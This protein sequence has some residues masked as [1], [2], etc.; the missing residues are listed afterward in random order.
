[1]PVAW[2]YILDTENKQFKLPRTKHAFT[3]LRDSVGGY[4]KAGLPN[5]TGTIGEGLRAYNTT[6][7][8]YEV[9][10][11]AKA[12]TDGNYTSTNQAGFD[13]SRSSSV[14][15]NSDTVQPKATQMYLYFFVGNYTKS[16]IEQTAGITSEQLNNKIDKSEENRLNPAGVVTAF[17]GTTPPTGWLKCDGSAIS[18]ERYA[19]LFAVI[20][21]T[22]GTGDG[23]T[24]FNLPTQSVLPL[25]T[26]ANVSVFGTGKALGINDG[27][28]NGGMSTKKSNNLGWST[29]ALN[30]NNY[31]QN[32]G[33]AGATTAN[34][35]ST[36]V[37][38]VT[39]ASKSGLKGT[40][41]LA[42]ATGAKAIVCIKY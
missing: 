24:T 21:T 26:S 20:G 27:S 22:Y 23:S 29:L 5:I 25:G 11:Y 12:P 38:V 39:D 14:Y 2:Y 13:A 1:M 19:A 30:T 18:R 7:A 9:S 35:T 36:A 17:A 4:V 31:N 33:Y 28:S 37:G 8:F 34:T 41:N 6:G 32:I 16:A 15:G 3:G 40:V 42:N 10:S